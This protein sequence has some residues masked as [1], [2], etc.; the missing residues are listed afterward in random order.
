MSDGS[1]RRRSGF[2]WHS[3]FARLF[4]RNPAK[5]PEPREPEEEGSQGDPPRQGAS[6]TETKRDASASA[7]GQGKESSPLP[8]L[9]KF[10]ISDNKN[11]STEELSR[12]STQEELKKAKSL[13][14]LGHE[15]KT[16]RTNRQTK[17]GF[18]QYLGSLFG[19]SS[20]SSYKENER[21]T[22]EDVQ[23]KTEKGISDLSGH[24]K[25]EHT[26]HLKP[27][28][29]V[30]SSTDNELGASSKNED[31]KVV[32]RTRSGSQDLQKAQEQL[33]E[34][35][36][37]PT[38]D[39]GASSVT[40]AT[41]RGSA[42]IKQLLKKQEELEHEERNLTSMSSS[43]V[44]IKENQ[45]AIFPNSES[46]AKTKPETEDDKKD[47]EA[48]ISLTERDLEGSAKDILDSSE[49]GELKNKST[50][51][52]EME[53]IKN[54][55]EELVSVKHTMVSNIPE[56]NR[57]LMLESLLLPKE[58]HSSC[59]N[60]DPFKLN[61]ENSRLLEK[62]ENTLGEMQMQ[63]QSDSATIVGSQKAMHFCTF[64]NRK[65]TMKLEF[66]CYPSAHSIDNE[67][68]LL[69]SKSSF[70]NWTDGFKSKSSSKTCGLNNAVLKGQAVGQVV[71]TSE[72][73][74]KNIKTVQKEHNHQV[75]LQEE[76]AGLLQDSDCKEATLKVDGDTPTQPTQIFADTGSLTKSGTAAENS[77][78]LV[79][80]TAVPNNPNFSVISKTEI[81][82]APTKNLYIPIMEVGH[83]GMT[84][85][86]LDA[87]ELN[88]TNSS[89]IVV[90]CDKVES[91]VAC[92]SDNRRVPVDGD[93]QSSEAKDDS[94]LRF[95]KNDEA[96]TLVKTSDDLKVTLLPLQL[97]NNTGTATKPRHILSPLKS[98]AVSE[99]ADVPLF[100]EKRNYS[101]SKIGLPG[102][103]SEEV[104]TISS[105][106]L[107][108]PKDSLPDV[109]LEKN[110]SVPLFSSPSLTDFGN[111]FTLE[112]DIH[113]DTVSKIVANCEN[114]SLLESSG[115]LAHKQENIKQSLRAPALVD[116]VESNCSRVSTCENVSCSEIT[117]SSY[118]LSAA[119]SDNL[120]LFSNALLEASDTFKTNIHSDAK[121][122]SDIRIKI[123]SCSE[124]RDNKTE[125]CSVHSRSVLTKYDLPVTAFETVPNCKR[126]SSATCFE[127][128]PKSCYVDEAT[129]VVFLHKTNS[130]PIKSKN[131]A[132]QI[133][134]KPESIILPPESSSEGTYPSTLLEPV[135]YN[136]KAIEPVKT[137][138]GVSFTTQQT[139]EVQET[140]SDQLSLHSL[141]TSNKPTEMD[142]RTVTAVFSE[143]NDELFEK[144]LKGVE[145]EKQVQIKSPD[146]TVLF[147]KADEIVDAVLCLAIEEIISKQTAGG[148]QT[149]DIKDNLL[150]PSLQKDQKTRKML[151]ES[152]EIPSNNSA[153]K[154]A[155]ES[156]IR[157]L[158]GVKEEDSFDTDKRMSFDIT[159]EADLHCSIALIA[160]EIIDEVINAAK[161]NL[162][163]NQHEEYQSKAVFQNPGL[164][165]KAE[166]SERL[167]TVWELTAECPAIS[168]DEVDRLIDQDEVASS[169]AP[170]KEESK[171]ITDQEIMQ[172]NVFPCETNG[173]E[174]PSPTAVVEPCNTEVV[175]NKNSKDVSYI[176]DRADAGNIG[177][178][179]AENKSKVSCSLNRKMIIT[180]EELLSC[181]LLP[182]NVTTCTSNS[183]TYTCISDKAKY[184]DGPIIS[185]GDMMRKVQPECIYKEVEAA[186]VLR[187]KPVESYYEIVSEGSYSKVEKPCLVSELSVMNQAPET[188]P[189][190]DIAQEETIAGQDF[191]NGN[192]FRDGYLDVE[193]DRGGEKSPKVLA[194]CPPVE[195]EGDSSF[196]IL[197]EGALHNESDSLSTEE[198]E[199][200]SFPPDNSLDS[201]QQLTMCGSGKEKPKSVHLY[202]QNDQSHKMLDNT[203]PGTFL[204]VEAK[205]YRVY[206]FSLSPIYEDD[207]SQEDLHSTD[208]SPGGPLH[209]NSTESQSLS[210]LSLLQSVSERLKSSNCYNEEE[211]E[212]EELC[213][214][215]SQENEAAG[216]AAYLDSNYPNNSSTAVL[217]N[218][219]SE[220]PFRC[221]PFLSSAA[222][223]TEAALPFRPT[224]SAQLLQ[225]ADSSMKSFSRSAYSK[226]LH[227]RRSY[228]GEKETHLGN[229]LLPKDHQPENNTFQKP[230]TSEGCPVDRE[231]L[232][233][234]PR[235]GK[236]VICD[237]FGNINKHEIYHDVV[238]ATV[239]V[240]SKEAL[241]TVV[242][243]CWVLY[244]KPRYQG[245]KYVLEEGEKML[246]D[247]LNLHIEEHQESITIGSV[248]QIMKDCS[249]PEIQLYPQGGSDCFAVTIQ[250]AVADVGELRVKN[251]ALS[252]K[253]GVWLA[254]SD[255]NYKGTVMALEE[256]HNPCETSGADIKSLRPLKMGSL[257]VQMPLNVKLIIYERSHFGGW[258]KV[259]SENTDHVP[260]LFENADDFQ[261]VGSIRVVGGI[262][263]AYEKE[264]YKGQQYLLE[265]GEYEDWHSWGGTNNSLMSLRFLQADFMESEVMLSESDEED[266]KL[267]NIVNQEIPDLEL[268][269]FGSVTRTVNVK[270]G[271]WV[272]YQQKYFCGEQYVLEKGKYKCFLD[273]GGSSETIMSI[274]P[275]KLEPLGTFEPTHWLKAFSNTHFR[276]SCVD[277]T[278]EATD[279]ESFSPCSFKVLRGC[280]LLCYQGEMGEN[281][282]VLEE[283]LYADLA[284]CG[285]PAAAVKS[286]KPVE[287]VFAEPF[288][289]LFALKN[290][291][292]REL[293]LQ[294]AISSVVNK[295]LH[296]LTQSVWVRSGLWIAY[297]GCHFLGKQFLLEPSK[298][299]NWTQFSGWKLVG[300]LR[301][302]KQ[303]AVYFRIKNRSQEKYLTVTGN[304][305]DARASSVCLSPLNYKNTQIWRYS[306]G[307]I[308]CKA[309]DACLD[310]IGG[311]DVPGAKVALWVE[312]GKARQKWTFNK[313]GTISSYLSDQLVLDIKGGYYYDRNH[314]VVN[315]ADS[316]ESSQ[317]WDFEIL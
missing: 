62:G 119:E 269:G 304:L 305:M 70:N 230:A 126:A 240:L 12:S 224:F 311:R 301:P 277:F 82:D 228:L 201:N 183:E 188:I 51:L 35:S 42:R 137:V 168:F 285:C 128:T 13:P 152:K 86:L 89:L 279:L 6:S 46:T 7:M 117:G 43:S 40:Y 208:I 30:I 190:S 166:T 278:E 80:H 179:T 193:D 116:S 65:E 290:Y 270:S 271:V 165:S 25:S 167:T 175:N 225:K 109:N 170:L 76:F 255:V 159:D 274:R 284:S 222:L 302:V 135:A 229:I 158:T 108:P 142:K 169:L 268:D 4:A 151:S 307:L 49:H 177:N 29:F 150:G 288:I 127:D 300:S 106:D 265:E 289:S 313:D 38:C 182:I 32:E 20:K 87:T 236:M 23:N 67:Q 205:R 212:E 9:L 120:I 162:M 185:L 102:L 263:V 157:K 303:P 90:Q 83:V 45:T 129:D 98:S 33:A 171:A 34:V 218:V 272:A 95:A 213:E 280:W 209:E 68:P 54:C 73:A 37:K 74:H 309:N 215:S 223:S 308:K 36:K 111:S 245:Q 130:L 85:V 197:Y 264:R 189:K 237:V 163:Y 174:W 145:T 184:E 17:E 242:R 293:R 287:Y 295:D 97:E 52:T 100:N 103:E 8:E 312:H 316:N 134:L 296:F 217:E 161:Q 291:E 156:C 124:E 198:S 48:N 153:L 57:N 110:N 136:V 199:L 10:S 306:C 221:S 131:F 99:E 207:S 147:K 75:I 93:V 28:V 203:C 239:W 72:D 148:C 194:F 133:S 267:L 259:I 241:I 44:G 275:I 18:F 172:N 315:Q 219:E 257:K 202:K 249:V 143:S 195:W 66:S 181:P 107:C 262:W 11:L 141:S 282:C 196:T 258:C 260:M 299:S 261:G 210:V 310:V 276:G 191:S 286:L 118:P 298:I 256:N 146:L 238:D 233:C 206:P 88:N 292:G 50:F 22:V 113:L 1:S 123:L 101:E 94:Y 138:L 122:V 24:E 176:T 31:I 91:Q 160:K 200:P 47:L 251:P 204:T 186:T 2:S 253:A 69:E 266:G 281:Q 14:S 84:K 216:A 56:G 231:R 254:Y 220:L 247:I 283:D 226:C 227:S 63:F 41:Y 252:V 39:L 19:I 149:N 105:K 104:I 178:W 250:S 115:S 187:E 15:G 26:T 154:H 173:D 211:E 140:S 232:K 55:I 79:M 121:E 234:N 81:D 96:D 112:D 59:Q 192:V 248:R 61:S 164:G 3:S 314:I 114:Q 243:G 246:C 58:V 21:A 60:S 144:P 5:E 92:S 294:E 16:A 77:T 155:N 235:P 139:K 53:T 297:E 317:K 244:E 125:S 64:S 214:G 27:E 71:N 273:W 132:G 78:K 180:E